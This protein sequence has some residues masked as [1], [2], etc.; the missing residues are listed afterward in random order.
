MYTVDNCENVCFEWLPLRSGVNCATPLPH[1]LCRSK[2]SW[3]HPLGVRLQSRSWIWNLSVEQWWDATIEMVLRP[4]DLCPSM[5]C[6]PNP[7]P[8][9]WA[10]IANMYTGCAQFLAANKHSMLCYVWSCAVKFSRLDEE[11]VI[12]AP[13]LQ[14]VEPHGKQS[15]LLSSI[16]QLQAVFGSQAH[17]THKFI[18][19]GS[20]PKPGATQRAQAVINVVALSI[21]LIIFLT[22]SSPLWWQ[23]CMESPTL[24]LGSRSRENCRKMASQRE[25]IWGRWEST[26][27]KV[28]FEH[29]KAASKHHFFS[30]GSNLL[31]LIIQQIW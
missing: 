16:P 14:P 1:T 15:Y 27:V 24:E 11:D 20:C 13:K 26:F 3:M 9:D 10:Q 23:V 17:L 25:R 29:C 12:V 18:W 8:G 5:L 21:W 6:C 4:P 19:F 28:G 2:L 22:R 30:H 7:C 31:I